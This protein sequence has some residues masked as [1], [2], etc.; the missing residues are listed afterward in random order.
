MSD[1]LARTGTAGSLVI[2]GVA[3]TGYYL[4]AL[5]AAIVLVG[6]LAVR[7]GFRSGRKAGEK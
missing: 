4:V 1:Q 7:V 3:L 2:G 5:A 6:A